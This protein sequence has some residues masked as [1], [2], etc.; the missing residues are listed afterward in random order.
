MN[1]QKTIYPISWG[2][3]DRKERPVDPHLKAF[4]SW[5]SGVLVLKRPETDSPSRDNL[6]KRMRKVDPK[7]AE[8]IANGPGNNQHGQQGDF[9]QV[10]QEQGYAMDN[11]FSFFEWKWCVGSY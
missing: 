5:R 3:I 1:A 7:Q 6:M 4:G 8:N 10:L 9:L 2:S 11:L